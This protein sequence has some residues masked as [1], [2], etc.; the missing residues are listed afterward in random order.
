VDVLEEGTWGVE[1][2][3]VYFRTLIE[4]KICDFPKIFV[5]FTLHIILLGVY[6]FWGEFDVYGSVHL[7]NLYVQLE[8]QLDV[9][10]YVFFIALYFCSKCFGCYLHQSSGT[11]TAEYSLRCV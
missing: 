5:S 7:G 8:V 1:V 9:F 3:N 4:L 2:A 10:V 6:L 11:Q